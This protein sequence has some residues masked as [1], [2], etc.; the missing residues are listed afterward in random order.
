MVVPPKSSIFEGVSIIFHHPF[1]VKHPYF[2]N[3]PTRKTSDD[4]QFRLQDFQ[5]IFE[6]DCSLVSKVS[7]TL[8]NVLTME[9]SLCNGEN[10]EKTKRGAL[11]W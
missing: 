11:G 3:T 2:G 1:W 9:T 6:V 5:E 8:E 10:F 7:T 4:L